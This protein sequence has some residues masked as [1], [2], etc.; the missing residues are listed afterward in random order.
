MHDLSGDTLVNDRISQQQKASGLV[1][2]EPDV[3][4]VSLDGNVPQAKY[5]YTRNH[6][7]EAPPRDLSKD[8]LINDRISQQQASAGIVLTD[9]DS[10]LIDVKPHEQV[11]SQTRTFARSPSGFIQVDPDTEIMEAP[12]SVD[13]VP[14]A[15]L[16]RDT[17]VNER[18]AEQVASGLL[19]TDPDSE[20]IDGNENK[21]YY[22]PN[23][24]Q[25]VPLADLS[26]DTAINERI[27]EQQEASGLVMIDPDAELID[28]K[29][30]ARPTN[31]D[32]Y[33]VEA[34]VQQ[35]HYRDLG[36]GE[37]FRVNDISTKQRQSG[38]VMTDQSGQLINP[39][40]QYQNTMY[41]YVP[42]QYEQFARR[43][44][45]P[46]RYPTYERFVQ[47]QPQVMFYQW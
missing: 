39:N 45:V 16:S 10:E 34:P 41:Y 23:T 4:L 37:D 47:P 22:V 46:L 28:D 17:V 29:R 24:I 1:S 13:H 18:A 40:T 12:N 11:V 26:R 43:K 9:P 44:R 42:N 25:Q 7:D 38:L 27:A 6:I 33:R 31:G 8:T 21:N 35:K 30:N 20:F 36:L 32:Y 3:E 2:I 15:D 5:Y 14:A 19:M